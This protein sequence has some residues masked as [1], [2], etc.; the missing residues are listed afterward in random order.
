MDNFADIPIIDA[1]V[2]M[3][4]PYSMADS[5]KNFRA[6]MAQRGYERLV[7][8][9][10]SESSDNHGDPLNGLKALWYKLQIPNTY[11]CGC[12]VHR[13]SAR[14]TAEGYENQARCMWDM[15]FDGM[16]MLEGKPG[17]RRRIGAAGRV[18]VGR[19]SRDPAVV[20]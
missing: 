16:K 12:L 14:D 5:L 4:M 1:H 15:G 2:H 10:Y 6:T 7:F 17:L 11:A 3:T 20:T 13:H 18:P 19:C 9:A 8:M